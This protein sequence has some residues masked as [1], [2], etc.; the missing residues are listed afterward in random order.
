MF[1]PINVNASALVE[2]QLVTQNCDLLDSP[3]ARLLVLDPRLSHCRFHDPLVLAILPP[4]IVPRL[5]EP[6]LS[7]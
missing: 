7:V 5:V 3:L 2:D 4:D 1:V 6:Q